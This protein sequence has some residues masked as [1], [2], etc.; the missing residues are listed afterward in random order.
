MA[1]TNSA[2]KRL[3]SDF[4]SPDNLQMTKTIAQ[5]TGSGLRMKPLL[6]PGQIEYTILAAIHTA[7]AIAHLTAGLP[8]VITF[9]SSFQD[10]MSANATHTSTTL[11]NGNDDN[12][13]TISRT[14]PTVKAI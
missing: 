1:A 12:A 7:N 2:K 14:R 8:G 9:G 11:T 5:R 6:D 10:A 3:L 4:Q 13:G